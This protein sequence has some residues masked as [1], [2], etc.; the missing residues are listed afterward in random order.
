MRG[1]SGIRARMERLTAQLRLSAQAGCPDCRAQEDT[2]R[3]LCYYG[4]A[5]PNIPPYPGAK[6]VAE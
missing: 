3:V 4:S 6:R 2:P 5:V 1:L